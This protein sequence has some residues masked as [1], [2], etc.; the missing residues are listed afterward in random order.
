MKHT[1]NDWFPMDD[2]PD[3]GVTGAYTWL[4]DRGYGKAVNAIKHDPKMPN[5]DFRRLPL[6]GLIYEKSLISA[7]L[8]TCWTK[9]NRS[10]MERL[11]RMD[12][13]H[14]WFKN[15]PALVNWLTPYF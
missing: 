9:G 2:Y 11:E 13:L 3:E 8:K 10:P 6:V 4:G 1:F 14:R 15:R 7:F 5:K 12:E